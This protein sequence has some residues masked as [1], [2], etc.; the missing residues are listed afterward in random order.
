MHNFVESVFEKSQFISGIGAVVLTIAG[1]LGIPEWQKDWHGIT[2][3]VGRITYLILGVAVIL[4]IILSRERKKTVKK[5]EDTAE[6]KSQTIGDLETSV[7]ELVTEINELFNSYLK[8]LVKNLN[9][10]YEERISVYKIH[11]DR[12]Q[13][14]GRASESTRLEKTGRGTYPIDEGFIG[15]GWD[16]GEYFVDDLPDPNTEGGPKRYYERVSKEVSISKHIVEKLNMKSRSYFVIRLEGFDNK[17][18]AVIVLESKNAKAFNEMEVRSK[19]EDSF[20]PLI[21]F[22]ETMN[23]KHNDIVDVEKIGL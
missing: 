14:I 10:T 16:R 2:I 20:Q 7:N 3:D 17:P 18:K 15:L 4:F 11:D 12:F 23:P 5:L 13:L 1:A 8:L 22:I 6:E 19:I 21:M 9:L